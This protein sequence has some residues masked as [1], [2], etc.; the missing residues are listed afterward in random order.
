MIIDPARWS[1]DLN[2]IRTIMKIRQQKCFPILWAGKHELERPMYSMWS[3]IQSWRPRTAKQKRKLDCGHPIWC[4]RDMKNSNS[5]K[6][7]LSSTVSLF[8][9][10]SGHKVWKNGNTPL[11]NV[12]GG[13]NLCILKHSMEK[14][15][16]LICVTVAGNV[17]WPATLNY[18]PLSHHKHNSPRNWISIFY[19]SRYELCHRGADKKEVQV[20]DEVPS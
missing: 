9:S 12:T 1:S 5:A 14:K 10:Q 11:L 3:H 8:V 18:R 13:A 20:F 17:V 15:W 6:H 2:G 19:T 4:L 16:N 7:A